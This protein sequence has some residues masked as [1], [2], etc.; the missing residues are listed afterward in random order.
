MSGT[1][2]TRSR[3]LNTPAFNFKL[4]IVGL[5]V[6][7]LGKLLM[8]K[9]FLALLFLFVMLFQSTVHADDFSIEFEW[10]ADMKRC[11][12]NVSPEIKLNNVPQGTTK[13][14]VKMVDKDAL[15][16]NH[17]GG[18]FK[19]NGESSIPA[20]ALNRWEGPCPPDGTHTYSFIVK[21]KGGEK[22]KAS[23]SQPFAQ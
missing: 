22:A 5:P 17:G 11:F 21:T 6:G 2:H 18:K 9:I 14:I 20:G 7:E 10:A 1:F 13:L 15:G 3:Y 16:Y 23:F 19:Y 4:C 8:K 12:S